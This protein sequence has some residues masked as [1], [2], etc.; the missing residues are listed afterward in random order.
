[1]G[2]T[3]MSRVA[4]LEEELATCMAALEGC[5]MQRD[6]ARREVEHW[7]REHVS[8]CAREDEQRRR[9][10]TMSQVVQPAWMLLDELVQGFGA[11]A[12]DIAYGDLFDMVSSAV[13]AARPI[14]AKLE[15]LQR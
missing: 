11:D 12:S 1:M 13:E 9:A 15:E 2:V 4:F 7:Q 5:G 3:A 14:L 10:D 8:A 6:E